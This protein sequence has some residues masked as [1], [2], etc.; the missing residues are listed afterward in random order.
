M[1]CLFCKFEFCWHCRGF[2]GH[3]AD[4]FNPLNPN[5]CGIGMLESG[6]P[7]SWIVRKLKF[8][9]SILIALLLLPFFLVFLIP[10]ACLYAPCKYFDFFMQEFGVCCGAIFVASISLVLFAL[11]FIIDV[12]FIPFAII[13]GIFMIFSYFIAQWRKRR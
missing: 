6:P 11:G 7:S 12:V 2:A 9:G 13:A 3:G 1:T 10:C 8:L 4:H 5:S